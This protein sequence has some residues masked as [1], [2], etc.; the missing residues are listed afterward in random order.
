M[1]SASLK[2]VT[3]LFVYSY[4]FPFAYNSRGSTIAQNTPRLHVKLKT[5]LRSIQKNDIFIFI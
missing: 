1:K 5:F 3:D 4:N 2:N